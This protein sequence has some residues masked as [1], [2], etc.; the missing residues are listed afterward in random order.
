MKLSNKSG[1]YISLPIMIDLFLTK[2]YHYFFYLYDNDK[3]WC[4]GI[5]RNPT[6]QKQIAGR[7]LLVSFA[8]GTAIPIYFPPHDLLIRYKIRPLLIHIPGVAFSP[9]AV[10]ISAICFSMGIFASK[11][12]AL[13]CNTSLRISS[14]ISQDHG[15]WYYVWQSLCICRI[16]MYGCTSQKNG[17]IR[18]E[19]CLF[20]Q[21]DAIELVTLG[22]TGLT[23]W[24]C[25]MDFRKADMVTALLVAKDGVSDSS[26]M[27]S[28]LSINK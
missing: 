25:F 12:G 17:W 22:F 7:I 10:S 4:S 14:F 19:L 11:S 6:M 24:F 3:I 5:W 28:L 16:L 1:M 26:F 20:N 23:A 8:I 9:Y 18:Q 13:Q 21:T 15:C 27:Q 2:R